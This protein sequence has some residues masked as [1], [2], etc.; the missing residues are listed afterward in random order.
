MELFLL[1]QHTADQTPGSHSTALTTFS[2][3]QLTRLHI[4]R[5]QRQTHSLP[6]QQQQPIR[7][8]RAGRPDLILSNR[9]SLPFHHHIISHGSLCGS[10]HVPLILKISS[11]PISIPSPLIPDYRSTNWEGFRNTLADTHQPTQL[12][13][14]HYTEIDKALEQLH[15]DI[16]TTANRH[17]Y[18]KKT[19]QT[20]HRLQTINTHTK[21]YDLL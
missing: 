20:P 15:T 6:T 12:E 13:G 3:T 10:D 9:L 7:T 16:V 14:K 17:I 21:T 18:T 11:N 1:P 19:P 4:S 5:S 2:T 8:R